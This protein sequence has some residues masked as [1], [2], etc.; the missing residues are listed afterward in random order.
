MKV[1]SM[2]DIKPYNDQESIDSL[3]K[4]FNRMVEKEGIIREYKKREFY[5]KPSEKRRKRKPQTQRK[6]G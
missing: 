4:R 2:S 5:E 1:K 6:R 3:I